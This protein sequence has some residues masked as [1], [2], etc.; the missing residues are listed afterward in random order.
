[1]A[2]VPVKNKRLETIKGIVNSPSKQVEYILA[3]VTFLFSILLII[4]VIYPTV[5]AVF[6]I[7]GEIK[8]KQAMSDSLDTKVTA[9]AALDKEYNE[10]KDDFNDLSLLFPTS[11]NFSLFLSNID[12]VV[13]NNNFVLN[14][15]SFSEYDNELYNISTSVLKPWS[16]RLSVT[17]RSSY[18][19]NLLNALEDMPMYPVI[20]SISY[21][22]QTDDTGNTRYSIALRIY[23]IETT[24]FYD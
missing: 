8:E 15:V 3:G 2:N 12:A 17:G 7:Q 20:E 21:S 1:M 14:S 9:L 22:D 10:K 5:S 6:S 13:L 24:K 23:H 4:F 16:V 19:I 11:G 18:L